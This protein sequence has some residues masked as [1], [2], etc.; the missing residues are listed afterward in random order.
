MNNA[1]VISLYKH[2]AFL[3]FAWFFHWFFRD[4]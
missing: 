3:C 4:S 1:F 2:R